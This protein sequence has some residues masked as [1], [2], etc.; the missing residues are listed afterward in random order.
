MGLFDFWKNWKTEK[1]N[2]TY[3]KMLNNSAPIFSQFGDNVYASDV[4]QQAIYTIV[5]EMKKLN[6]KHI[7]KAGFDTEV[8]WSDVQR[9]LDDPNY[10]MTTSDFIEKITWQ[11]MLNYNAFIY[12]QKD[13][14]G[15]LVGL[16]PLNPTQVTF[17]DSGSGKLY[18]QLLFR[19]GL[20]YIL[21]YDSLIH[22]KT[23]FSVNDLMG[24]NEL[25]QPDNEALLKTLSLNNIL[26]Q[27][28][29]KALQSSFAIN[30]IVKYNTMLDNGKMEAA[31]Q[32]FEEKLTRSTSGI[33]PLDL[34]ADVTQWKR[35]IAMVDDP[36]L[37]FIDDKIL[38]H[39]GTP[40]EIIRGDYTTEQYEAFYQKTLEPLIINFSQA[41]SK[42]LFSSRQMLG[43]DNKIM[44][45]PKELVFM[46]TSQKISMIHELAP[47]GA[48]YS[49]EMRV[50]FGY[51]PLEELKGYRPQSLNW[52]D[53][54]IAEQ[55]QTGVDKADTI[56]ENQN[57]AEI[58]SEGS[59]GK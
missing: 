38:R 13:K 57:E 37:K 20:E 41:F 19:N 16:Y 29:R 15:K 34:K 47:T 22:I 44:F 23:H 1:Q 26:L 17:L 31:I 21:P 5:T 8:V 14:E 11:V 4:V 55:Y 25:G 24:G 7:R 28:V 46:S 50:A 52:V 54:R 58:E 6:P 32:D 18:V 49:N 59:E 10:L 33:L 51:E 39:F 2:L 48:L 42:A 30:G 12:I 35:E 27:G 9:V 53:A 45:Y 43:F 40:V 3:A 36:T 56:L